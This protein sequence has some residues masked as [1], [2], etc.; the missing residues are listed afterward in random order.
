MSNVNVLAS[1]RN[2]PEKCNII[3]H[4]WTNCF[5]RLLGDL[6]CSSLSSQIAYEYLQEFIYYA[7]TFYSALFNRNILSWIIVQALGN[8]ARYRIVVVTM[9]SS[10]PSPSFVLYLD[11]GSQ[12]VRPPPPSFVFLS[13]FQLVSLLFPR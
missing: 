9:A 13:D 10:A 8:L 12:A 3:I 5:Y 7:Y 11:W 4:L 1:L 6:R 2:I